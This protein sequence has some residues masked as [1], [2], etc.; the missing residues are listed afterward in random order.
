MRRGQEINKIRR[1]NRPRKKSEAKK[2]E[3]EKE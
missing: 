1:N 2:K 3:K